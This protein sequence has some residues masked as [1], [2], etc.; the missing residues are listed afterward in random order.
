MNTKQKRSLALALACVTL[1]V[2]ALA[3]EPSAEEQTAAEAVET[4]AS[5]NTETAEAPLKTPAEVGITLAPPAEEEAGETVPALTEDGAL[6]FADIGEKMREY[7]YPMYILQ[8][9][10]DDIEGRD[11][12]WR[13]DDLRKQLNAVG[14]AQWA[15]RSAL[16]PMGS[17]ASQAYQSAY[18]QLRDQFDAVWDGEQQ[19]DDQ[20]ALWQYRS[21][22]NQAIMAGEMLY[23]SILGYREQAAG[24]ERSIA[25]L[26][27]AIEELALRNRLG[28]VSALTLEQLKTQR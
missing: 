3:A 27:R 12:E 20:D 18:D 14:S 9:S 1:T 23:A 16:G 4:A 6:A 7:Y 21:M 8:E 24:V 11:Y 15:M 17:F 28:Q 2:A 19:Q 5:E 22:Q 25:K 13:T 10:I 26:D